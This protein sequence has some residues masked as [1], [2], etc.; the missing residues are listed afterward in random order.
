MLGPH[1]DAPMRAEIV[2]YF[3]DKIVK[4][5]KMWQ[6]SDGEPVRSNVVNDFM[7]EVSENLTLRLGQQITISAGNAWYH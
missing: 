7:K 3:K 5:V 6:R 1:D 2:T 4:A